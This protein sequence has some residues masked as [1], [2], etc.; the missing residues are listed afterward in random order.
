MS[1]GPQDLRRLVQI[2][3][4]VRTKGTFP[5]NA[6]I[7]GL[8]GITLAA[9]EALVRGL[10][11]RGHV[12]E[13]Q[14]RLRRHLEVTPL[15]A[16]LLSLLAEA[17]R[18]GLDGRH[19]H[20]LTEQGILYLLARDRRNGLTRSDAADFLNWAKSQSLLLHDTSSGVWRTTQRLRPLADFFGGFANLTWNAERLGSRVEER[21][22]G[23]TNFA[24]FLD[25]TAFQGVKENDIDAAYSMKGTA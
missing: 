4:F 13:F 25:L 21:K 19:P 1:R 9:A 18:S 8:L 5:T 7:G 20:G 15:Y 23:P 22:V 14:R 16:H 2:A 24:M 11:R 6:E 10:R 17:C 3:C 12:M